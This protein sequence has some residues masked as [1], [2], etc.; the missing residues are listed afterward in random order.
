MTDDDQ[1]LQFRLGFILPPGGR[2]T[3]AFNR[4]LEARKRQPCKC[5]KASRMMIILLHEIWIYQTSPEGEALM[6]LPLWA[7]IGT[8]PGRTAIKT[9]AT[10]ITMTTPVAATKYATLSSCRCV[11]QNV[12]L[13]S[14]CQVAEPTSCPYA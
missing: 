7:L 6:R 10:T 13:P 2:S 4:W 3:D 1:S 8:M 14:C 5:A 11:N 9:S 12:K